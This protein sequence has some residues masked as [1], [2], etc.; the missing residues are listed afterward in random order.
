MQIRA[1]CLL[2]ELQLLP[3]G[4]VLHCRG[5]LHGLRVTAGP[6]MAV[7]EVRLYI[8]GTAS[9]TTPQPFSSVGTYHMSS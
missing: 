6:G 7:P 8:G 2:Q 9:G 4:I 5:P 3:K 1:R